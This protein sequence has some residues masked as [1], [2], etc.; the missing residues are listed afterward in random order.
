MNKYFIFFA[1]IVGAVA[2]ALFV[3]NK[4]KKSVLISNI[5]FVCVI[6]SAL[7][8]GCVALEVEKLFDTEIS[9]QYHEVTTELTTK[10]RNNGRPVKEQ[11]QTTATSTQHQQIN[12][13]TVYITK[14]GKKYHLSYT[15]GGNEYYECTIEQALERGLTPCKKCA[16]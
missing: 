11:T 9:T 13:N 2:I 12:T 6:A 10:L 14:S 7:L 16:Q 8:L 4:I 1:V 3:V 5:C 15:C